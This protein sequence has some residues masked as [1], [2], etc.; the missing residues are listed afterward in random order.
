VCVCVY[1]GA[2][3]PDNSRL[4]EH[5]LLLKMSHLRKELSEFDRGRIFGAYEVCHNKRQVA[6]ALGMPLSTVAFWIKRF[7]R[8]G[9]AASKP[10][11]GRPRKT[12]VRADRILFRLA[13]ANGFATSGELLRHWQERVSACTVLRRL[14]ERHLR[15]YRPCLVPLLT[16]E[17]KRDRQDWA[18]RRCHWRSQWE[19]VIW[20]DESRYLLRPVDG[21][22]VVWRLPGER[23]N[24]RFVV[25]VTQAGGGSVHV[26]GAIWTGGR[27]DLVRLHG[28]VN[29]LQYS[30]V[31]H[32][33]FTTADLPA[34]CIFQ[35][36]NA[37]IHRAWMTTQM[38]ED[39]EVQ[40]LPWPS[41][42]PDLNP[43]EHV[44]DILGR[45]MQHR[46]PG[47]LNQLFEAL[48]EEWD[49]I[50]QD[51]LDR[52][53]SSMPRRVGEVISKRGSHTQY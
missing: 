16:K 6:R 11:S 1:A 42:S 34:H 26:W 7:E 22:R 38:L 48:Q 5:S 15:Q 24:D 46:S 23:L 31:L 50:P 32:G 3:L 49:A 43:I 30:D 21:R 51:D 36:D 52:L 35:Q 13:R 8:T 18:M 40:L 27:S 12:S 47:N 2:S 4:L 20:S 19:R 25:E 41:R 33:F 14:H 10:R 9:S 45:R 17:Q 28:S 29:A 37:P 53:I 39:L 44:W